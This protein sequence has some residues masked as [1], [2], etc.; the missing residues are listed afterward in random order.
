ML[1]QLLE[2]TPVRHRR[3]GG[4]LVSVALHGLVLA[5][6]VSVT[7]RNVRAWTKPE[8]HPVVVRR[9]L[10]PAPTQP[11]VRPALADGVHSTTPAPSSPPVFSAP[12]T[13][14][15]GIPPVDLGATMTDPTDFTRE[16]VPGGRP[17]G[18]GS[19]PAVVP[20]GG[21]FLLADVEKAAA[22]LPGSPTPAYPEM[23]KVSGVEGDALVQFVVDTL[24]RAEPA[25]FR[26]LQNTHDAFGASVRA[27][28][29]RMR[30][31][32]A[33]AGGKK[34]RMLV[35]QRFAFSLTR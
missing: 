27:T 18:T 17:D 23:L 31:V 35:Q 33:E 25:S 11:P 26:V 29:A 1:K 24:G 32:P 15:V 21:A 9:V 19:V 10:E 16:R 7:Q 8:E 28:L 30:F 6:A 12:V 34:V 3:T 13:I 22:V 14:D 2:T 5:V 20:D 4:T